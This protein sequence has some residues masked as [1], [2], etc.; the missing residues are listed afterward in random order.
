MKKNYPNKYNQINN[1]N[2]QNPIH[3]LFFSKSKRLKYKN[4][5]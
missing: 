2:L 3:S 5:I 4:R 1:I